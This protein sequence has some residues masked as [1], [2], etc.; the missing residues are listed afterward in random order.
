[1]AR[2]RKNKFGAIR[3]QC[4]KKHT[5]AS[6]LESAVCD[7]ITTKEM[8][9]EWKLLNTEKTLHLGPTN[10]SYR[11]DFELEDSKGDPFWIEAKGS[12][13]AGRWPETKKQWQCF[14]PGRLEVWK[15]GK[16]GRV[17]LDK[18][19]IPNVKKTM[20]CPYCKNLIQ[21]DVA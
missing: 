5:H 1:M 12:E 10:Y 7:M 14:G 19:I 3:T 9:G 8:L 6:K 18:V 21:V 15:S 20:E 17:Y 13:R 16:Q 4:I 2:R 11:V